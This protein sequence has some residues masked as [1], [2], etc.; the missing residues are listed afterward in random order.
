[1]HALV[2][3]LVR[4]TPE[5]APMMLK[6]TTCLKYYYYTEDTSDLF[7]QSSSL[8]IQP[9]SDNLTKLKQ[10][11]YFS[12]KSCFNRKPALQSMGS[13]LVDQSLC[14]EHVPKFYRYIHNLPK[15]PE[16]KFSETTNILLNYIWSSSS[17]FIYFMFIDI[18][19]ASI[20]VHQEMNMDWAS[21]GYHWSLLKK[22]NPSL[23]TNF[24][25]IAVDTF[26]A[27]KINLGSLVTVLHK[28]Y[29][30]IF[31]F[32]ICTYIEFFGLIPVAMSFICPQDSI[33]QNMA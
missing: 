2:I 3:N 5:Y 11:F 25:L 7:F 33:N 27:M 9:V 29:K 10:T 17:F 26:N 20:S 28:Y 1:M 31:L 30:N 12:M 19:S 22:L 4:L 16:Q 8:R 13:A 18:L 23:E 15:N 32:Y 6:I 14:F 24:D 21:D